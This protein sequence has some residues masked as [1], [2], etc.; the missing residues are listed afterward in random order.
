MNSA[1]LMFDDFIEIVYN[2]KRW[3]GVSE[4]Q[5]GVCQTCYYTKKMCFVM[6]L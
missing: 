5:F 6:I 3:I 1:W 2:A 4:Y